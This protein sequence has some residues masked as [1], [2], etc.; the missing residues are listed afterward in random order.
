MTPSDVDFLHPALR[1][2]DPTM[3][4]DRLHDYK[5]NVE[6]V[7][8]PGSIVKCF[9]PNAKH[10]MA[11]LHNDI[12]EVVDAPKVPGSVY[13][14]RLITGHMAGKSRLMHPLNFVMLSPLEALAYITDETI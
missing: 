11:R 13:L 1:T 6:R 4:W 12:A 9:Y 8:R 2:V 14:C 3:R 10:N 7:L 5:H